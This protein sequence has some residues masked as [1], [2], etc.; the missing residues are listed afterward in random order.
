MVSSSLPK[1]AKPL[2]IKMERTWAYSPV[3]WKGKART[4]TGRPDYGIWFVWNLAT[5]P[6]PVTK[7]ELVTDTEVTDD[8]E[9]EA[10]DP[11]AEATDADTDG[12]NSDTE[13]PPPAKKTEAGV[14]VPNFLAEARHKIPLLPPFMSPKVASNEDYVYPN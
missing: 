13:Q 12:A 2:N 11:E 5:D 8:P 10:T 1:S 7:P 4:L 6:K 9:P 14:G 3:K